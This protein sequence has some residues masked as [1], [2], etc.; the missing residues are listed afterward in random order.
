M[1]AQ[2]YDDRGRPRNESIQ[3][4]SAPPGCRKRKRE[5]LLCVIKL[6]MM[7]VEWKTPV[8]PCDHSP[9]AFSLGGPCGVETLCLW[10]IGLTFSLFLLWSTTTSV[11]EPVG[12]LVDVSSLFGTEM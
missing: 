12:N 6:V 8:R 9:V 2:G 1:P 7:K 4:V 11:D 3:I 5:Q 10:T